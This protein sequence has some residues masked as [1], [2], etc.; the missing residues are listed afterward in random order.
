MTK[1]PMAPAGWRVA[2]ERKQTNSTVVEE[3]IARGVAEH[4]AQKAGK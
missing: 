1:F 2:A 3:W 4:D